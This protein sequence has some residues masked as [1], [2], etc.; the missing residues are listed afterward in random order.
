MIDRPT[1]RKMRLLFRLVVLRSACRA[2]VTLAKLR[3][4]E[5]RDRAEEQLICTSSDLTSYIEKAEP[6]V[7][8]PQM[9]RLGKVTH[10]LT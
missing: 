10:D 6:V 5:A 7:T 3:S 9:A 1:R 2:A 4:Q 8:F